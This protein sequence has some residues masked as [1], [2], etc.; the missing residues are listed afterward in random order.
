MS[1]KINRNTQ[2]KKQIIQQKQNK[3]LGSPHDKFFKVIFSSPENALD[4]FKIILPKSAYDKCQWNKLK[5]EKKTFTEK[6]ADL[7]FSVPLKKKPKSKIK[8]FILLEHKS[9][10]SKKLYKQTLDYQNSIYQEDKSGD[11]LSVLPILFYHGEKPWKW[12]TSFKEGYSGGYFQDI[13]VFFQ[14]NML[15]YNLVVFDINNPKIGRFFKDKNI[16]SRG[17]LKAL[18]KIW[19]LKKAVPEILELFSLFTGFSEKRKKDLLVGLSD[20][21]NKARGISFELLKKVEKRAIKE[22]ILKK[23]GYMNFTEEIK[24]EAKKEGWQKGQKEGW[25]KG[26]KEGWQK[27]QKEGWQEG[28]KEGWQ[29]GRQ[30][31]I[32]KMLQKKTDIAFISEVTGLSEKEIKKLKNGA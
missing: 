28:Q 12:K 10:Y 17:A 8:I 31:V 6:Q 3:T 20:Y 19:S 32:L 14:E 26:Q 1:R 4:I 30:E 2:L 13:P 21:L 24:K 27:G 18:H 7:I 5:A 15:N 22:G 16:K 29:E 9:H 11:I 23:G 25:Q